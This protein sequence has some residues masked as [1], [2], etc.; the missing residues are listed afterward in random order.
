VAKDVDWIVALQEQNAVI[1]NSDL[2]DIQESL[3]Q[4]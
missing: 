4:A 3:C 1:I 2:T